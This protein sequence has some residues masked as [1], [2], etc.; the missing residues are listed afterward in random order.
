MLLVMTLYNPS[1]FKLSYLTGGF[2]L[3]LEQ[4]ACRDDLLSPNLV[5]RDQL[6][7]R[8]S[9]MSTHLLGHRGLPLLCKLASDGLKIRTWF[10]ASV[11]VVNHGESI[12]RDVLIVDDV[13]PSMLW[14]LH[15]P[16]LLCM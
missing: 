6:V 4:P 10:V 14:I 16:M 13:G 12:F 11:G 9:F 1:G 3:H 8:E 2:A 15:S 5:H 7:G